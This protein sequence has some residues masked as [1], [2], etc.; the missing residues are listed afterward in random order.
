M[1]EAQADTA[2]LKYADYIERLRAHEPTLANELASFRSLENVLHWIQERALNKTDVDLVGQDEF[3]YDFL[4][5]L[6]SNGRW[7]VFGVT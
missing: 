7:L 6:G 4:L 1:T 3:S 2:N 5:R